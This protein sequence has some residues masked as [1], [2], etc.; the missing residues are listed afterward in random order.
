MIKKIIFIISAAVAVL[1]GLL[2]LL[3]V[4]TCKQRKTIALLEKNISHLKEETTPIRFKVTK[5]KNGKVTVVF[6]FYDAD[7]KR[8]KKG[9]QKTFTGNEISFDFYVYQTQ[10]KYIAFPYK[11]YTDSIAPN[12][13]DDL[14]VYYDKAGFPQIFNKKNMNKDLRFGLEALFEKVK[15]GEITKDEKYFGNMVHDLAGVKEFRIGHT[16]KII[17]HTKGGIEIVE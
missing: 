2:L 14:I 4:I 15:N 17:T 3:N 16:Y 13:G 11:V 1:I 12:Q 5:R 9:I 10:N 6:A 7:N 8:I